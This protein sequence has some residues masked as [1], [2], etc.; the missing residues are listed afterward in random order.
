MITKK[1]T[2]PKS[3]ATKKAQVL[4]K[5]TTKGVSVAT[6]ARSSLKTVKRSSSSTTLIAKVDV[7]F[8]NALYA[9]GEGAGLSW[10]NGTPLKNED[11]NTWTLKFKDNKGNVTL[12]LL[13]NDCDWATGDNL[14][15]SKGKTMTVEPCF[16]GN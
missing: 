12:K 16:E 4:K 10:D 5:K 3:A 8:G 14:T 15:L 13:K 1:T 2:K 7:G 9:R 6:S 11:G